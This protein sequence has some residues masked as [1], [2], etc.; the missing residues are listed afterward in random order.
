[1]GSYSN[2][3]ISFSSDASSQIDSVS[4]R[5]KIVL[6]TAEVEVDMY[7]VSI[8]MFEFLFKS[9]GVGRDSIASCVMVSVV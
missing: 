1:M 6:L 4:G 2:G 9:C 8:L 7:C 3:H 5:P